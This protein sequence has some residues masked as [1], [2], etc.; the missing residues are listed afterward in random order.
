[1][2]GRI[3]HYETGNVNLQPY[4]TKAEEVIYSLSRGEINKILDE[5]GTAP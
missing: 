5:M 2:R 1:M 4:G 3:I